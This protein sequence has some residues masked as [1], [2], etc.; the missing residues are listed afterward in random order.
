M[1]PRD[2]LWD[3]MVEAQEDVPQIPSGKAMARLASQDRWLYA[4]V[5]N[6]HSEMNKYLKL[7]TYHEGLGMAVSI[8]D[9]SVVTQRIVSIVYDKDGEVFLT[10]PD[11]MS[12]EEAI[13]SLIEKLQAMK[14]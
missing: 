13:E 8:Y 9:R 6:E 4:E 7:A 1:H 10:K 2:I 14:G 11:S 5:R 12:R 3:K